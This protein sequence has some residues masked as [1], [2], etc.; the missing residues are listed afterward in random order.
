MRYNASSL[1]GLEEPEI[2]LRSWWKAISPSAVEDHMDF[3][4]KME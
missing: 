3:P 2:R 1:A 4:Q